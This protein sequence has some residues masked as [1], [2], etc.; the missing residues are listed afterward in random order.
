MNKLSNIFASLALLHYTSGALAQTPVGPSPI[1]ALIS[2]GAT[3]QCALFKLLGVAQA[4]PVVPGQPWFALPMSNVGFHEQFAV[5]LT[6][7]F[8]NHAIFLQTTGQAT[9]G[10]AQVDYLGANLP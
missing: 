2:P 10:F 3:S 7:A 1:A 9:C 5:L 4:D 8:N 6:A